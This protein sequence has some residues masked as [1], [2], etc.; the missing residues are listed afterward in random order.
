MCGIAWYIF[1]NLTKEQIAC[2]QEQAKVISH[3]GPDATNIEEHD[4][5][6][7]AFHRLAI[8]NPKAEGMQPFTSAI[9]SRLICNGEIYNYKSLVGESTVRSDCDAV[10]HV[11]DATL[12]SLDVDSVCEAVSKLDGDFAFVWKNGD[13]VIIGRD[14]VGVYPLFYGVN[15]N[16]T[17]CGVAS[18]CKALVGAPGVTTV[19]V[20]PPGH[21]WMN[22]TFHPYMPTSLPPPVIASKNEAIK[23]VRELIIEAVR[24]RIDHSDRPVGVLCSG[25][26]DSSIVAC[27][28][29]ELG[30]QDRIHVFTMEYEGARS[31]D[32]F[33]ASM[34]C[35]KMGLK[36]T[37]FS[38]TREEVQHTLTKIPKVIETYDPNT[39]RAAI[40][41]YL[42]AHKIAASTDVRVILSGE[43]ADELFHGYNY[44]RRAPNPEAARVEAARLVQNLHM[45]DLL[46]AERCFSSAGLEVRVPFLDQNLV[47][48][49]QSLDGSLPWGGQGYAEK[50][51]LRDAF[52]HIQQLVDLRILDRPKERFSDGCGFTYVPQL[53]NDISGGVPTLAEKLAAEKKHVEGLFDGIY[54]NM[55]HLIVQRT[56]PEWV[57][58]NKGDDLLVM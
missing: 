55:R 58:E 23:C 45:F 39:V 5:E 1:D 41:M 46:R 2:L 50:Q 6:L 40:P 15:E 20:F 47:R 8:I 38:F 9:G 12:S 52:A 56:M 24:K 29:A 21:V 14:H 13:N 17:L 32:A 16:D 57:A 43:G 30:A 37:C 35:Q 22:G 34:L 33:F 7:W 36:H 44:F 49:V 18:E 53:L 31:E 42:L 51:L 10:L 28:V 19:K 25:G 11:L 4:N 3:R 54:L 48:Y 27:L 26:V